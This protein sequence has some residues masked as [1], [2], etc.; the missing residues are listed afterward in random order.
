MFLYQWNENIISLIVTVFDKVRREE[1]GGKV[2]YL[3]L[4]ILSFR[5]LKISNPIG[6]GGLLL[7]GTTLTPSTINRMSYTI[8]MESPEERSLN[9]CIDVN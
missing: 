2:R 6:V 7:L 5:N 4:L 3:L 9:I 8:Q 1:E